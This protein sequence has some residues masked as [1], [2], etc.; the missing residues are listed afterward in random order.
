MKRQ[1]AISDFFKYI[2]I[3]KNFSEN[4]IISYENDLKQFFNF[5]LKKEINEIQNVDIREFIVH[6]N[7]KKYSKASVERKIATLK[8]F[9]NYLKKEGILKIN[10]AENISF[11][12]KDK[13]LPRY[14]EIDEINYLLDNIEDIKDKAILETLYSTGIRVSELVNLDVKDIDFDNNLI[15]VLGKGKKE[16]IVPIGLKA[17]DSIGNYLKFKNNNNEIL[18]VNKKGERINVRTIRHIL[19]KCVVKCSLSKHIS[20]HSIRHSFATHLLNKGADLRSV[21]ELLGHSDLV[22][23]QIYTHI[24]T[25]RLKEV[26]S[27]SHPRA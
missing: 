9:F 20:P 12:K 25:E 19:N 23:T 26:Y 21:Q 24:T 11:P 7:S 15:K 5:V 1:E 4:T 3:E 22:T 27:K 16:R 10:P 8:S 18:F 6:L 14:L 13:K 2:K 17:L